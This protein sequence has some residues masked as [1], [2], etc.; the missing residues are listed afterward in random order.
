MAA[1]SK[2][3]IFCSLL[4]MACL[5]PLMQVSV[6]AQAVTY[7]REKLKATSKTTGDFNLAN[8]S[9][10]PNATVKNQ[11]GSQQVRNTAGTQQ[12]TA[13]GKPAAQG[14]SQRAT[15]GQ[16]GRTGSKG[17]GSSTAY[18]KLNK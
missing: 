16:N 7:G 3:T 5:A 4:I 6:H 11:N 18:P 10:T 1:Q 17:G 13:Q 2:S 12:R 15:S 8:R 14:G 9:S